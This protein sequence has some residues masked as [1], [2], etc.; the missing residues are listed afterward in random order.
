MSNAQVVLGLLARG[1]ARHG[2]ELKRAHDR[3]LSRARPLQYGYLYAT[4]GRLVRDGLIEEAATE[5]E[6]GPARTAYQLTDDGERS[7]A[8]WLRT[9]EQPSHFVTETLY[10]KVVIAL[11]SAPDDQIA[12]EYLTAQHRVHTER[13]RALTTGKTQPGVSLPDV[14][15]ADFALVHLEADLRWIR[16]TLERLAE[17][18]RQ[19]QER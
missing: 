12:R 17:L 19:V 8:D 15:A 6:G 1:E 14:V 10:T 16:T 13:M 18:R 3:K 9:P 5:Q 4:L 11:L 7:L 2:Y